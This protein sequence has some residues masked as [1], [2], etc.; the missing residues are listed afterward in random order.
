MRLVTAMT[1]AG[2]VYVLAGNTAATAEDPIAAYERR[3]EQQQR[4]L[5]EMRRE[6]EALKRSMT[7]PASNPAEVVGE[8]AAETEPEQNFVLRKNENLSLSLSG[9][10]HRM[11]L[12]VD[13]GANSDL[14][15]TDSEQGPTML[16]LDAAGRVSDSFT[17]GAALET[18]IRQNRPFLVSQDSPESATSVTVRIAEAYFE[19]ARFGR[20]SL[21]RGFAS[22]WMAPEIDLSG[23]QYASLLPVGMLAPGMKFVNAANNSLSDVQV[24]DHFVDV[25]RLLAADRMRYDSPRFGPGLQVSGSVASD[26]RWDAALRAKPRTFGDWMLVGGAAYLNKPFSTTDRRYD[27]G[28]SVLHKPSG[29]NLTVGGTRERLT[30]G[31]DSKSYVIKAGWLADLV[32]LGK[33]AF[34]VD[35]YSVSDL[36]LANDAGES[37]GLFAVQKW[38]KYGLDMYAGYRRY[39]VDRPDTTLKTLDV[40]VLGVGFNF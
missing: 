4:E 36:R 24:L 22:A 20:L 8:A 29:L 33:T 38:P 12:T 13:D 1:L 18:G 34:S 3:I 25:E 7:R 35:Y 5:D 28:V 31:R 16:R 30:S 32:S 21:G 6:L 17:L 10:V 19:S 23:T 39:E 40:Y 2:V 11:L 37:F 9:R 26:G 14:F 27:A 15:F